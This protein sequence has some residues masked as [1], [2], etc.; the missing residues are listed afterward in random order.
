MRDS[1]PRE[2]PLPP[3]VECFALAGAGDVLVPVASALGLHRDPQRALA[4][5]P[6]NRWVAPEVGHLDL[7]DDAAVYARLLAIM[8]PADHSRGRGTPAGD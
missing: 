2:T 8:A 3:G 1:D 7:L 5:P 6:P 4:I